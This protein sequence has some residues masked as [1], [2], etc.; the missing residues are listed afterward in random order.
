MDSASR[1]AKTTAYLALMVALAILPSGMDGFSTPKFT[2]L[3]AGSFFVLG[4]L[5]VNYVTLI[6]SIKQNR[7]P[8]AL[9]LIFVVI[10][11]FSTIA[12]SN[13]YQAIFGAF[14]RQAGVLTYLALVILFIATILTLRSGHILLLLRVFLI[15]GLW[16]GG[17]AVCQFMGIEPFPCN[18]AG[19]RLR[20]AAHAL[21]TLGQQFLAD[22][23]IG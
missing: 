15:S 16:V 4:L 1:V 21:G 14:G 11:I 18:D 9:A 3:V 17:Y 8:I 5:I 12:S 22:R 2:V 19:Q 23:G 7:I 13:R 6:G 10:S 20:R